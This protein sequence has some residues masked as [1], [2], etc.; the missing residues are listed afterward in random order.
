M[1]GWVASGNVSS[2][3]IIISYLLHQQIPMV[4][5]GHSYYGL[6]MIVSKFEKKA[7]SN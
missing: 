3:E 4:R 7:S 5:K 2:C 1:D 6:Y